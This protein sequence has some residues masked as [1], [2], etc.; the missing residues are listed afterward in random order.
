MYMKGMDC[1]YMAIH[2]AI[3]NG[4]EDDTTN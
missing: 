2:N 4:E 1:G 3:V